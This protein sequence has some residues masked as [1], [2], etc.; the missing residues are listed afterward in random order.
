MSTIDRC[1]TSTLAGSLSE[2]LQKRESDV[3][4]SSTPKVTDPEDEADSTDMGI[5]WWKK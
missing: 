1:S 3:S 2:N 5:P 4:L